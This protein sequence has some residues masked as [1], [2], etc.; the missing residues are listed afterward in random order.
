MRAFFVGGPTDNS[1][2]DMD[3]DG[4]APTHYP[5]NTGSGVHRYRLQCTAERDGRLLYAV[6]AAPE[7]S[8]EQVSR[9]AGERKYAARFQN[10]Q[11][12]S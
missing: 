4:F 11:G 6:Y 2:M 10:R 3:V 9:I 5:P 1:E 7:L 12:A 8:D